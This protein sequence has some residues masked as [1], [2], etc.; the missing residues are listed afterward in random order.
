[1]QDANSQPGDATAAEP[2]TFTGERFTPETAG[3]IWYEHWHRY[4]AVLPLAR[5]KRVL[6][7]AS[8]EGY[9]SALLAS[10]A[11][12]VTGI[13]L[14][15]DAVRHARIRYQEASHLQ[16]VHA[17]VT[18]L[19]LTDA[20]MDLIVSFETIEHLQQQ[21]AMLAEFRR[22][23]TP[24]GLLAISSPNKPEYSDQRAFH[25][26]FHVKELTR[27]ELASLLHIGFPLQRWFGQR[28]QFH[29]L[30]WPEE[31][32]RTPLQLEMLDYRNGQVGVDMPMPAP[33]Y[34]LVVCGGTEAIL[35]EVDRTSLF[36]D[37]DQS[38]YRE[39][40]RATQAERKIYR[41]Y[42]E[43]EDCIQ[44]LQTQLATVTQERDSLQ[45]TLQ[46]SAGQ[47]KA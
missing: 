42:L 4:C 18:Q 8:G 30:I 37:Q 15:E 7:A 47:G 5:G 14:S 11:A 23:L 6:D 32:G 1:M 46:A 17:P 26:E 9:G 24:Q 40:E 22:V 27:D 45:L 38:I 44:R 20:S 43:Q 31:P 10:V 19:P 39:F 35:P 28:L 13:D 16:F 41:L 36:A 21:E 34:F 12:Q 25:N 3:E 2:L 33:M 29:S